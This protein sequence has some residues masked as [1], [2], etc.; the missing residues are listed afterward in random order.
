MTVLFACHRVYVRQ[1]QA[2]DIA[3]FV[4]YRQ[5]PEVAR[6]QSWHNYTLADGQALFEQMQQTP[7]AQLGNWYQLAIIAKDS[8]QLIGDLAVHFVDE[9]QIEIGFTLAPAFQGQGFAKEALI[10]CLTWLFESLGK[11]RVSAITDCD[12]QPSWRLLASV[13]FRREAHWHEN[14]FFKGQW[15]SEYGYALLAKEWQELKAQLCSN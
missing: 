1:F 7:F 14:I 9:H 6:Y 13:G 4:R 12:N 15:G 8:E 2:D 5:D 11:H 3:G 10:G